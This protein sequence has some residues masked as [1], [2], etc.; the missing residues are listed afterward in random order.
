M[1]ATAKAYGVNLADGK[2]EDDIDGAAR[3][4]KDN[5]RRTGGNYKQALSIYNS[6]RPD[7]YK[8]PSFAGGQTTDYVRKI[9]RGVGGGPSATPAD[10]DHRPAG[11]VASSAYTLGADRSGDRNALLLEWVQNRHKPG[12][13][14]ALAVG[15]QGAQDTPGTTTTITQADDGTLVP[16]GG[17][18]GSGGRIARANAIDA[19]H[20]DY[21][22]GG[23]H[24]P[25]VKPSH[26]TGHGSGQGV[27]FDCSGAVA[28]VLGIDARVSGE[29]AK[30]GKPGRAKGGKGTTVYSNGTHVLME[31]DG[32][33]FGTS[34]SNKGGGAGWIPRSQMSKSYLSQF[35]ARHG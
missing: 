27:G 7:A 34:K 29:F 5:L 8:D 14:A 4:M 21:Q 11:R 31:I 3:Y 10:Q 12:A 22:W 9:M 16:G 19:K 23:G 32:R 26:G 13:L 18:G 24:N 35:T 28:K 2:A 17:G 30:W 15:M 20:Y 6:G 25:G 1:P 33:F